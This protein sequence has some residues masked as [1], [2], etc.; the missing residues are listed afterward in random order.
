LPNN[1]HFTQ[2]IKAVYFELT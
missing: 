2:A 1:P